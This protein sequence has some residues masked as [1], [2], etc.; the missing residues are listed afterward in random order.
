MK[1]HNLIRTWAREKGCRIF[2]KYDKRPPTHLFL[3]GGKI[4]VSQAYHDEFLRIYSDSVENGD[5]NYISEV[6]TPVFRFMVD[7]DFLDVKGISEKQIVEY[8]GEIQLNVINRFYLPDDD[9][10]DDDVDS[11]DE[12]DNTPN[13]FQRRVIICMTDINP[14]EMDDISQIWVKTGVHLIWPDLYVTPDRALTIRRG[15]IN[16][17]IHRYGQ[18]HVDNNWEAVIDQSVYIGSGL[19]MLGSSKCS[20]CKMCKDTADPSYECV[21]CDN[22][23]Y[24]HEGREYKIRQVV[25]GNGDFVSEEYMA[26]LDDSYELQVRETSIRIFEEEPNYELY[27]FT[28]D[29]W[30]KEEDNYIEAHKYNKQKRKKTKQKKY[31][32]PFGRTLCIEDKKGMSEWDVSFQ[33]RLNKY[34]DE[35]FDKITRFIRKTMPACYANVSIV[36][37]YEK[38]EKGTKEHRFYCRTNERYCMNKTLPHTTNTIWFLIN[39]NGLYQKCFSRKQIM[40][41]YGYCHSYRSSRYKLTNQI[42]RLLFGEHMVNNQNKRTF[43]LIDDNR[44]AQSG[45]WY[46]NTP[47]NHD[48]IDHVLEMIEDQLTKKSQNE[49]QVGKN[50][51]TTIQRRKRKKRKII[52]YTSEKHF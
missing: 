26:N 3:N 13:A 52:N 16:Y 43:A 39:P 22:D 28:E 21:D 31:S 14:A 7:M 6:R 32:Y 41:Q 23:K 1:R 30:F 45:K 29:P 25:D 2:D 5:V 36:E 47:Q 12:E 8:V 40:Y 11:D 4:H 48:A 20:P 46:E 42:K 17:L 34:E 9:D 44:K 15:I 33:N 19:R 18:R 27:I 10:S 51:P 38:G 50:N 35:R 24:I 37:I 49:E